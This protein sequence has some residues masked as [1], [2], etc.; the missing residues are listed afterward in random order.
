MKQPGSVLIF[1]AS[2]GFS[3]TEYRTA[4]ASLIG[5][6]FRT[7]V[8]ASAPGFC[9][10]DDGLVVKPDVL[11][12]NVKPSNFNALLLIGG[13]GVKNHFRDDALLR[14]ISGFNNAGKFLAA[15]CAAPVLLVSA[16]VLS[17]GEA[18]CHPSYKQELINGKI[19]YSDKAF[20]IQ[21]RILTGKDAPSS[22]VFMN[23]LISML[24]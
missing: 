8:F 4:R 24:K 18:A 3:S 13:Q 23:A 17:E 14:L 5:Q 9:R 1:L 10:G 19:D 20:V 15:I 6:G 7:F 2:S 16:G 22:P 21:G 12:E 11:I